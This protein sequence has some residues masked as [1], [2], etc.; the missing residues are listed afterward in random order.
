[1]VAVGGVLLAAVDGVRARGGKAAK[2]DPGDGGKADDP[3]R[4]I[5]L[6]G[7]EPARDVFDIRRRLKDHG[8]RMR[9]H[10]VVNGGHDNPARTDKKSVKF[11]C[12]A[13]YSNPARDEKAV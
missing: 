3:V 4:R 2:T 8:G 6:A 7:D 12:F 13:T 10:L 5:L 9:A 1:M 11:M